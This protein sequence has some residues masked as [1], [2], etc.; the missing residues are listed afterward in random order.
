[1]CQQEQ[2]Q[3]EHQQQQQQQQQQRIHISFGRFA[4]VSHA[5]FPIIIVSLFDEADFVV[6][7]IFM[8]SK[9]KTREEVKCDHYFQC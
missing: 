9:N 4:R 6:V 7:L 5:H 2:Q 3:Q 8:L 1:M